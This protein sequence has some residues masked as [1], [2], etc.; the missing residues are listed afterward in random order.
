VNPIVQ[1]D[2]TRF[3]SQLGVA[4]LDEAWP[5]I[6]LF[7]NQFDLSTVDTDQDIRMARIFLAAHIAEVLLL[8]RKSG[9]AAGPVTGESA[10]GIRRSYG[11][12][13]SAT[14]SAALQSTRY[15]QWF[16]QLLSMSQ[17]IAG[18]FVI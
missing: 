2:V 18:P 6:L 7:V 4:A 12:I 13:S 5:D 1:T 16:G 9:G 17:G 10:G 11:L 3:A 15:G 8:A 14:S